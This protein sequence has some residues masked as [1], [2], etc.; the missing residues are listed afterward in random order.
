MPLNPRHEDIRGSD[1]TGSNGDTNR[2]YTLAY[3]NAQDANFSIVVGGTTLQPGVHYTKTGDLITFLNPILDSMYITLD[4]WTSDS[5]GSVTTTYCNAEDIQHE[6]QLSTAF[7]AST[8]PSLTTVNE[9]I[10]QAE[11]RIDQ[12]TGHSW[13]TTT[14]AEEYYSL[15]R[16]YEYRFGAGIRINLGH[17]RIKQLD[18][19]Q[20]DVLKVWNGNEY[21][22]WLSTR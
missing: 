20:G 3:S 2:T 6:L 1:L 4:Y 11:D 10:V 5:A 14:R 18:N 8:K 15:S 17:R 13:R 7:S 12:I 19:S 22:D 9:W 21:E 16:N